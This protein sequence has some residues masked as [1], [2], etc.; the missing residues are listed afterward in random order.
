LCD[1]FDGRQKAIGGN[2]GG[3]VGLLKLGRIS[4]LV[5]TNQDQE[6]GARIDQVT[7]FPPIHGNSLVP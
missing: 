5:I 2:G 1:C 7:P 6:V 3:H 4:G